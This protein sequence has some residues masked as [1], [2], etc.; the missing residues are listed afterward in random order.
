MLY[1]NIFLKKFEMNKE[2]ILGIVR[3]LLTFFGGILVTKGLVDETFVTELI[4]GISTVIGAVWSFVH[5]TGAIVA[6]VET[7]A[8]AKKE[9]K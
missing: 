9:K 7:P 5:K 2:Q 1:I 8:I 3:H 6:P 4:G